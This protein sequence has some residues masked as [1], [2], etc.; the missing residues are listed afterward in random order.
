MIEYLN[1]AVTYND[2]KGLKLDNGENYLNILMMSFAI[3]FLIF[4]ILFYISLFTL[5]KNIK[6]TAIL[7][8]SIIV[9]FIAGVAIPHHFKESININE[10]LD[11]FKPQF[12]NVH[13]TTQ[14]D[15]IS[16]GSKKNTQELRFEHK[17][18]NYYAFIPSKT[19][20]TTDDE[21]T[22]DIKEQIVDKKLDKHQLSQSINEPKNKVT[23]NHRGKTYNTT[24]NFTHINPNKSQKL[25]IFK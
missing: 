5:Q 19:P 24:L 10:E 8:T 16:N 22:I 21:I 17:G 13:I 9:C 15:D 1:K 11:D 4:L 20:V 6:L 18:E 2:L 25:S 7:Y 12:R 14:I 3:C 23:I